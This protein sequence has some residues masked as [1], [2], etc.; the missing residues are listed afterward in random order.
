MKEETDNSGLLDCPFC[1]SRPVRYI[2]ND[3]LFVQC[4]T[5]VSIGFHNHVRFGCRA[6]GEWNTRTSQQ[7]KE[8]P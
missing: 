2:N 4:K 7:P 6:D 8:T 1:G 5:C 3:I